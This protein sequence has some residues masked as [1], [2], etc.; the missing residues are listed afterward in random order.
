MRRHLAGLQ[1]SQ[2][3]AAEGAAA[4]VDRPVVH[5][6]RGVDRVLPGSHGSVALLLTD[7]VAPPLVRSVRRAGLLPPHEALVV[8]LRDLAVLLVELE[9]RC[10][11][12]GEWTAAARDHVEI[13]LVAGV[14]AV[15]E[16]GE[17]RA[18]CDAP[19]TMS[20]RTCRPRVGSTPACVG[21]LS[22]RVA[23]E[24]MSE[25]NWSPG[26]TSGA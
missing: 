8:R 21:P 22:A 23:W 14:A 4:V 15:H 16:V 26:W 2:R 13:D 25:L 17:R 12:V 11:E 6:A 3:P 9:D 1:E 24:K 18:D 7:D 20:F 5:G 10:R 19:V